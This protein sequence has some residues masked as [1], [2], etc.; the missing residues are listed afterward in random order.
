MNEFSSPNKFEEQ[1][2]FYKR[3]VYLIKQVKLSRFGFNLIGL[4]SI[5][6]NI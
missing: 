4:G 5:E 1:Q 2:V 3:K 6:V